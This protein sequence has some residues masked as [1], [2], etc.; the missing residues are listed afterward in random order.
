LGRLVTAGQYH[1]VSANHLQFGE[2]VTAVFAPAPGKGSGILPEFQL[3]DFPLFERQSTIIV[4]GL[5]GT[6]FDL[7]STIALR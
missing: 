1:R 2:V 3:R 6:V 7:P 4:I 5:S